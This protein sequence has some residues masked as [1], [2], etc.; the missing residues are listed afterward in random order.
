[1]PQ[2]LISLDTETTGLYP[3]NGDRLVEIGCVALDGR[4]I[5]TGSE[6]QLQLYINPEREVP[7]EA[8][9]VHGLTNEF[10]ADKPV[11]AQV[12]DRFLNFVKC[13]TLIIHNAAFDTAFLDMELGR[14]GKGRIRDY[15]DVIDTVKLAKQLLPGKA[16]SLDSLCRYYE[17]D[18]SSR[19]F[20]GALLD[21][22]LLAEVYLS[23]SRGQDS[24]SLTEVGVDDIP[25]I[26]KPDAFFVLKAKPEEL[27]E[28]ERI[29]GIA[30]KKCKALCAWHK[31]EAEKAEK[32]EAVPSESDA[33]PAAQ[34]PQSANA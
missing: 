16:V 20:H 24:L 7:Q 15:C 29:L 26:P 19:T 21:A 6:N 14:I 33:A 23:L 3:E 2:R 30:D 28:H 9:D 31:L 22:Q 27:A 13:S 25:P 34:P 1:M 5:K 8:I 32:A 10:L 4:L 12:A 17:I 18:N 11:F